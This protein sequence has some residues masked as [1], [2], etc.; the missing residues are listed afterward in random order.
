[1]LAIPIQSNL[2]SGFCGTFPYALRSTSL[3]R[4]FELYL[5]RNINNSFVVYPK[6]AQSIHS[7]NSPLHTEILMNSCVFVIILRK[8]E[9]GKSKLF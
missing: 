6:F 4:L 7:P 8:R 5:K 1:M 3:S 2:V 9:G